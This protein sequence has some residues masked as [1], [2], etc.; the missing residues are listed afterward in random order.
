MMDRLIVDKA[1]DDLQ[2]HAHEQAAVAELSRF[3]LS[4]DSIAAVLD[5][6]VAVVAERLGLD[7]VELL[8]L[9]PDGSRFRVVAGTGWK[10]GVVG[11]ARVEARSATLAGAVVIED[12]PLVAAD[13]AAQARFERPAH[14]GSLE[15]VSSVAVPIGPP[16]RRVGVLAAHALVPRPVGVSEVLWL[17]TVANVVAAAIERRRAE[18]STREARDEL[19]ALIASSPISIMAF[20][21]NGIVTLWNPAAEATFGWTAEEAIGRLLPIVPADRQSQ[22]DELRGRV[23]AGEGVSGFETT[24]RHKDG[25]LL[26]VSIWNAPVRDE[27]GAVRG[28]MAVVQDISERRRREQALAFLAE[29]GE[30]LTST[31]DYERTLARVARLAV[32][33]LADCCIVDVVDDDDRLGHALA[34]THVDP[35]KEALV[36]EL[37]R[38]YPSDPDLAR[39]FVGSVVREGRPRLVPEFT[40]GL[41]REIARDEEHLAAL[42]ELELASALC[43]PLLA[44]GRMLG[45]ITLLS[46]ESRRRYDDDDLVLGVDLAR[47]AALAVDNARLYHQ[48]SHI[49]MT[50]QRS[51]LPPALPSIPGV[52]L[53]ARYRPSGEGVEVGGDFFDVFQTA[54]NA[55]TIAIGDVCGKGPEAAAVTGLAR[56]SIRAAVLGEGSP[57][58]A[59]EVVNEAVLREFD[60]STFCTVAVARLDLGEAPRLTLACGG[61]PLPLRVTAGGAVSAV[62]RH[63]TLIGLF[64]APVFA[65]ETVELTAGDVLVFY[66]DGLVEGHEGGMEAGEEAVQAILRESAGAQ[67]DAIADRIEASV[68][69]A[70][71]AGRDDVAV[72]VARIVSR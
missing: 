25:R 58:R 9:E 64:E 10:E 54:E 3:A 49:A 60:A 17:R 26:D 22:F 5:K 1:T 4:A 12:G 40:E 15:I 45:A 24:R 38:R 14:L 8:L 36:A 57:S 20:D 2:A 29:A 13:E 51:L 71:G 30:A 11:E 56:H 68:A 53:A 28:V 50:L 44:R 47:L 66:T 23:L 41:I 67:A 43:L 27:H 55:W 19:A 72:L 16:G 33:R 59:L 69:E 61:H 7:L 65:D 37:E 63:G 62:G 31:L 46:A 35:K 52:E 21:A 34:V 32:P 18:E 70:E 42:R 39:S 48:R 6:A